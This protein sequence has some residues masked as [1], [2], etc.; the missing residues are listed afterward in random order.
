MDKMD[1]VRR[2]EACKSC[3]FYSG[4]ISNVFEYKQVK[5]PQ[6]ST[7]LVWILEKNCPSSN[8]HLL[9]FGGLKLVLAMRVRPN[10]FHAD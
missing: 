6:I 8:M 5:Y 7:Y 2:K 9:D 4:Q 3:F 10:T 1:T